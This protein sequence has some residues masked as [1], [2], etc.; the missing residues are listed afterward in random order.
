MKGLSMVRVLLTVCAAVALLCARSIAEEAKVPD[1]PATEVAEEA[2]LDAPTAE[3]VAEA[4]ALIDLPTAQ[5]RALEDN[6]SLQAAAARIAQANQR[7]W[8][9]RSAYMPQVRAGYSASHTNLPDATVDAAREAAFEAPLRQS[10]SSSLGQLL[11]G[12]ATPA[13][14]GR[15]LGSG[16]YGGLQAR[17]GIDDS[18]EQYSAS[19]SASYLIFDGFERRFT[20][21]AAKAGKMEFDAARSEAQRLLLDA[22]A[23]A[24]Y[25]VQLARE[26]IGIAEADE[27]FNRR[28]LK[29]A[30]AR[31]RVGTG[32][33]SDVLNFE[34]QVRAA[35]G[36]RI[37]GERDMKLA[38]VVLA[39]L[40]G[41]P[42]AKLPEGVA[43]APMPAETE[44]DRVVPDVELLVDYALAYRPDVQQQEFAVD[45]AKA[46]VGQRRALFY[47]VVGASASQD[48]QSTDDGR[49]GRDEFASTVGVNLSYDLFTGGRHVAALAESK[50]ARSEAERLLDAAT[51]NAQSEVRDSVI[52][53]EASLQLLALQEE[54]TSFVQRNRELVEKEY[55]AGQGALARL[56]QAQRDLVAAEGR[57]ALARVALRRTWHSVHTATGETLRGITVS[58]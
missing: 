8:Q 44:A 35:Q 17:D 37:A 38:E 4:A 53:L 39:T 33:L 36:D 31:R 23:Q 46:A 16:V 30:E 9:A 18:Q 26:S 42:D 19:L 27:S 12:T 6:P 52:N 54:T 43:V 45:R 32:S 58:E 20:V 48:Y 21:L 51:L 15:S 57:L 14:I 28:L 11:Q 34:V 22:V 56:N 7:V 2:V 47:P 24:F 3:A 1:A 29:D 5:R 49:P 25:S 55:Q 50:H 13:S 40:M 10:V 41:M